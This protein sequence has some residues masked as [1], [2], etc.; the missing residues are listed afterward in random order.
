MWGLPHFDVQPDGIETVMR[1]VRA[2]REAFREAYIK[3]I[4][5]DATYGRQTSAMSFIV[6][7]PSVEH[8]FELERYEDRD[9]V[10]RYRHGAPARGVRHRRG[11]Q[12]RDARRRSGRERRVSGT[13]FGMVRNSP[14]APA[15]EPPAE[16]PATSR[17]PSRPIPDAADLG[18]A[19]AETHVTEVLDQLDEELIALLPVKTR[20]R[21]I[22][23]LLLIDRLRNEVG[24]G[25]DRPSLHMSFTGNPGTGKTTVAMKMAQVLHRL[26]YIAEPRVV[27]CTRDD[28]VGQY[29][30][31]TAPKT[32]EVLRRA[33]GGVLFI[34]EAYYLY[35]PENERDYGQEAI[36]ILLQVME[37]ERDKLV[38]IFAGYKDRM[39]DFFRSNPGPQLAR[40]AP[41]RLPRLRRR[42][43]DG[44]RAPDDGAAEL[45]VRR[46]RRGGVPRV[47][48]AAGH[49]AAVR[50]RPQRAQLDR[51]GPP[52]PGQPPLR[53]GRGHAHARGADD[54]HARTTSCKSSVFAEDREPED[55][56]PA[57][58]RRV[59]ARTRSGGH[60]ARPIILGV[61][62]DSAAGKT[63]LTRGLVRVLG[64]DNV[65]HVCVDDYHRYDRRQRAERNIT[66]LHPDC[67]YMDIM[68][69]HLAHMRAGEPFLKPVY[70]HDD[71]TF[72]PP[73]RI[74]PKQF[75]VIDGLL[76]YYTE[77]LRRLY[78]VRVY[79][80]PPEE[81]RRKWKVQRD[82]SRRGY[83]T[84]QVLAE[85]DR[86]EPDSEAF[87]R[88]QQHHAD[89]VVSFL[90]SRRA[91]RST[92][93]PSSCCAR[94]CGTPTCA[95]CWTARSTRAIKLTEH[96]G[97]THLFI[98][99]T[100][101]P[102][103]RGAIEET[104]WER[105]HFASHLRTDRLGEF[106]IGTELHRSESLALIQLLILYHL[107]TATA[108]VALGGEGTREPENIAS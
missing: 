48:R 75:S 53:G 38:V 4:A 51:P 54:D 42:R 36:E 50:A 30:G 45:R 5:Y 61:V 7:R 105:L 108:S 14:A 97:E 22:A 67:N 18:A 72:G 101:R 9:R 19:L 27:A 99:G 32:K 39:D 83:T 85:L 11:Q 103:A 40:R 100:L 17:R 2:C 79:L 49:A 90:P 15:E 80:A 21:E 106:T 71:G 10:I 33:Y 31:H 77:D 81:L 59:W 64:E 55:D 65:T 86:R 23:A 87:I 93:T 57:L 68:A 95:R 102:R 60:M 63:T 26:G 44:D 47:P 3:V 76:G 34:D 8:G 94:R 20:I 1:E 52:A 82:C 29:V 62:G 74:E 88:P 91:T 46:R 98:P 35:R 24:L 28:L 89:I 58:A 70:R 13:P 84:D 104:I 78:D 92:S 107:F 16:A 12:R 69:Q 6:N 25:S 41:H 37:A 96:D 73:V 56:A 66:P 43:A